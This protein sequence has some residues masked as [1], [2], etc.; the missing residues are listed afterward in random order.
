METGSVRGEGGLVP[1]RARL[2]RSA[3]PGTALTRQ[4]HD[5]DL[6]LSE[7]SQEPH[8]GKERAEPSLDLV[9]QSKNMN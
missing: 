5:L 6:S 1:G 9:L 3:S 8:V 7:A 2:G 4:P